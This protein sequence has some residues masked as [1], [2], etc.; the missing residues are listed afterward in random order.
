MKY[1]KSY[2]IAGLPSAAVLLLCG[3]CC[4][5]RPVQ[6]GKTLTV[7]QMN[8]TIHNYYNDVIASDEEETGSSERAP[9][10]HKT[11]AKA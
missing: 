1:F 10:N 3:L 4:C 2:V 9:V 7:K 6:K 8:V 5:L 11:K